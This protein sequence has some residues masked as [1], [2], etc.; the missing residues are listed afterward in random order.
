MSMN[1]LLIPMNILDTYLNTFMK[2]VHILGVLTSF[3]PL[4]IPFCV[5]YFISNS[6]AV[7]QNNLYMVIKT[8]CIIILK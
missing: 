2:G 6:P 5:H 4:K 8:T 3:S 7:S 1:I